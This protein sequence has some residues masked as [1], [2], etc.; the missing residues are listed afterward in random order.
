MLKEYFIAIHKS[1][2]AH[3]I[4]LLQ[5]LTEYNITINNF[6]DAQMFVIHRPDPNSV[7]VLMKIGS[8]EKDIIHMSGYRYNNESLLILYMKDSVMLLYQD[9]QGAYYYTIQYI[10]MSK[11]NVIEEPYFNINIQEDNH[12]HNHN[13]N[14]PSLFKSN[15]IINS[16][17]L[18][19]H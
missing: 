6:Y 10:V 1:Q 14:H 3:W 18:L 5:N 4:D 9:E 16:I 15:R 12:N 8:R 13:H 19:F 11:I 7:A 2:S 17:M